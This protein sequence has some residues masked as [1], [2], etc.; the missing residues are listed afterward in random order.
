[1]ALDRILHGGQP[2]RTEAQAR[3]DMA[4]YRPLRTY[5]AARGDRER[6]DRHHY[7]IQARNAADAI[8]SGRSDLAA[9]D[10]HWA[11]CPEGVKAI[12]RENVET[13]LRFV[14]ELRAL[15]TASIRRARA[16][17]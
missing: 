17:E 7:R 14:R 1:M 2:C 5:L 13:W 8:R 12:R 15:H 4:A 10:S 3:A 11:D 6:A 16:G 9:M